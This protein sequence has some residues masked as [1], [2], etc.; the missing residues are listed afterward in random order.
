MNLQR[1]IYG[2]HLPVRQLMERKLVSSVSLAA[3]HCIIAHTKQNP[4]LHHGGS[5]I[6]LDILMGRDENLGVPDVF[7][8]LSM[9]F[10]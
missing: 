4:S 3:R 6:H 10:P 5:N 8:G 7:T 1:N 2:L 9:P